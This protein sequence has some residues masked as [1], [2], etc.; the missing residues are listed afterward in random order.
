MLLI[1]KMQNTELKNYNFIKQLFY[2]N[3]FYYGIKMYEFF[4]TKISKTWHT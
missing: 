1:A 4:E 2:Y 3:T